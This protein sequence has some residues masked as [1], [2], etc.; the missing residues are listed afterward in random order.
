M[1]TFEHDVLYEERPP[2]RPGMLTVLC[3]LTFIGSGLGVIGALMFLLASGTI[4]SLSESVPQLAM[5]A[6]GGVGYSI[7]T[8]LFA[9]GSLFGAIQ[10]FQL[11]KSG[12]Y[13]Y[14]C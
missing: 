2:E 5:I 13:L 11:K 10:M 7:I 14:T 3:I 6:A 12:F 8:L 1:E 9:A 4:A